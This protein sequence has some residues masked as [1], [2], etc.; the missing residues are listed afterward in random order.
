MSERRLALDGQNRLYGDLARLWPLMSPP[1]HYRDEACYWLRELRSRLSPGRRRILDLG[2][3][4]GHHL[5]PLTDEFAATAVDLSEDMLAHSRRLNPGVAHHVGDMRT[6]RLGESFDAVLIHDAISYMTTEADLHA[7]FA[8]AR[9]HL[10]PGGLLVVAPDDYTETFTPPRVE[11]RT[12][13][14]AETELTYIEYSTDLD[15]TDTTIETT[16]VYFIK[17][18]GKLQVEV[19]HHVTG[20]FPVA[21]WQRLLTEAGFEVERVDYPV[22]EDDREMWLWVGRL[23]GAAPRGAV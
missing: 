13:R 5:H 22:S 14:D 3:G 10:H 11:H 18:A 19:D 20:L 6:V 1:E 8:T 16:Y 17:R 4:G 2:S 9:A 12:S 7:V 21:T 23:G 15:P